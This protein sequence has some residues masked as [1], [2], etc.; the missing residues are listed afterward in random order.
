MSGGILFG[1]INFEENVKI[2]NYIGCGH[3]NWIDVTDRFSV[4]IGRVCA[5]GHYSQ[6]QVTKL[7]ASTNF[8]YI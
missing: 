8:L 4:L 2:D 1:N 6:R 7:Q 3:L 5:S